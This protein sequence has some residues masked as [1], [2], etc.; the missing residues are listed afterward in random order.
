MHDVH[1]RHD[2]DVHRR[3][4]HRT[5]RAALQFASAYGAQG[6]FDH[7]LQSKEVRRTRNLSRISDSR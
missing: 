5:G 1:E 4:R 6:D 2:A 7:W 3:S